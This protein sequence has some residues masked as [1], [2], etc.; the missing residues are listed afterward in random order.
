MR[1]KSRE[2]LVL[3]AILAGHSDLSRSSAIFFVQSFG[4]RFRS[5][6]LPQ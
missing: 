3:A 1:A 5:F 4:D 2:P 6:A